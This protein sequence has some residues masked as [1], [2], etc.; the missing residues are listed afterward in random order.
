MSS[1]RKEV[2]KLHSQVVTK[3][4]ESFSSVRDTAADR[5]SK[6]PDRNRNVKIGKYLRAHSAVDAAVGVA[7]EIEVTVVNADSLCIELP[8]MSV[9][10]G[11]VRFGADAEDSAARTESTG[12]LPKPEMTATSD[13]RWC[14]TNSRRLGRD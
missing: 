3:A 4:A 1:L 2:T 5:W 11:A 12:A 13:P 10:A 7:S 9:N 6:R 14:R 8:E